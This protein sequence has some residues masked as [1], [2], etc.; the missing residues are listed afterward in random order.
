MSSFFLKVSSRKTLSLSSFFHE[1][2]A[3]DSMV[4]LNGKNYKITPD[5]RV[6]A[7]DSLHVRQ[8]LSLN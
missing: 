3:P 1:T 7:G 2:F 8:K 4:P 5:E 6:T